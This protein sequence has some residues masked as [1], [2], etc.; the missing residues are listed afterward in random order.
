M[1]VRRR[2]NELSQQRLDLPQLLSIESAASNDF[3]ELIQ[4]IITGPSNGYVIRGFEINMSGA[5]G[6]AASSLEVIVDPGALLHTTSSVSGTFYQVATGTANQQLNSATNTQVNG[7]FSPN[8]INYVALEY[9]RFADTTTNAVSYFWAPGSN[10]ETTETVPQ[11]LILQYTFNISTTVPT[12]YYLPLFIVQTDSSNN[13]I[14]ITDAR[15]LLFRLGTGGWNPNPFYQYSWSDGQSENPSTS[16]SNS[17]SPFYGGDKQLDNLKDWMSAIMTAIQGITGTT[18]WY[19]A[20]NAG[21]LS[22]IRED[23]GNTVITGQGYIAHGKIPNGAITQAG[24]LNWDQNI[25]IKVIGTELTYGLLANPSST[26]IVLAD[27]EVAYVTLVRDVAITPNLIFTNGSAIV[28]S[29]G[30]VAWTT[31]LQENDWV[32]LSSDTHAGYYQ[33]QSVNSSTQVTLTEN[34]AESS[35][36]ATGAKAMYAF[37]SY[38]TAATP[39]TNRGIYI[40]SRG[41]VPSGENV[42]WLFMRNDN[43]GT[44]PKIYVRFL[45]AELDQGETEEI[46]DN[47]SQETLVYIGAPLESSNAP[48]YVSALN[49]SSIP[50]IVTLTFS[51]ASAMASNQYFYIYSSGTNRT[52][53]V[54]FNINSS[55]ADPAPLANAT[56]VE[57]DILS[58]ASATQVAAAVA[59]ALNGVYFDD[60]TATYSGAVTTVTNNS[61]G[62]TNA[63][64]NYNVGGLTTAVTQVGTGTGNFAINDGDNL[65]LAIKKLDRQ[66]EAF[67][68]SLNLPT[69]DEGLVLSSNVSAGGTLTLPLNSRLSNTQGMYVVGKGAL[70]IS[71]NGQYLYDSGDWSEIGNP[72]QASSTITINRA[73]VAG[74]QIHF[75]L[76][77]GGA[78]AGGG[79]QG[80]QG[81]IGPSGPAGI[82]AIGQLVSV[83][84]K[85]NNYTVLTSDKMLLADCSSNTVTF[86]LPSAS[87]AVGIV[88]IFKKIDSTSNTMVIAANGSDLIDGVSSL[89]STIQYQSFSILSSGS[90]WYIW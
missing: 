58:T 24:Q 61:A 11:A 79:S 22:S 77:S 48:M 18:Y 83:S 23:L 14:S 13:V 25:Y 41:A 87:S 36:G 52:Y 1:S 50:E 71:L 44:L 65:T 6:G 17:V 67:V 8:S 66:M 33:I 80:P 35:T 27:D 59:A 21:S 38:Q 55:G 40:S 60:F 26:N 84:T 81:E 68:A 51:A 82:N 28:T 47:K 53:Y 63:P 3:D 32:K 54:W 46:S 19:S 57:V 88:F 5:I 31:P 73:L 70:E 85:N 76:G 30:N 10:S 20:N 78:G 42:F 12:S 34:F 9:Q 2:L 86:S 43:A 64:S 75:R 89:T 56:G 74:D 16:T 7:A 39:T 62:T 69:Y 37:G 90:A 15:P 72:G 45:G 49:S 29:V 4:S